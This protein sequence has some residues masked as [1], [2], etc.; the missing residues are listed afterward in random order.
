[1]KRIFVILLLALC[2]TAPALAQETPDLPDLPIIPVEDAAA[3]LLAT[4]MTILI[5]VVDSPIVVG[6]VA[7]LKR[8]PV[9][10][11]V[12]AK[13][14]QFFVAAFVAAAWWVSSALGYG[15]Q[16]KSVWA[17]LWSFIPVIAGLFVRQVAAS[18]V[19]HTAQRFDVGLFSYKRQ[20][21]LEEQFA[22]FS[23][24]TPG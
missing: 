17:F 10:E 21:T 7:M 22:K 9:L 4:L 20:P 24:G 2:F 16:F 19:Y 1:M 3:L 6:I 15:P 18:A 5:G 8:I 13:W 23:E 14:L 12:P 11:P